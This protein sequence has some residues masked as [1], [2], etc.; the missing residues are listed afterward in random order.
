VLLGIRPFLGGSLVVSQEHERARAVG[1]DREKAVG[2]VDDLGLIARLLIRSH[3]QLQRVFFHYAVGILGEERFQAAD[4]GR[5]IGLLDGADVGVVF[6]RILDFFLL[7]RCCGSGL[8]RLGRLWLRR[9]AALTRCHR[10]Q[11][12]QKRQ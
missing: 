7:L 5:G 12:Q 11:R 4:L 10:T 2:R 9:C 1:V 6:R 8:R 3:Q